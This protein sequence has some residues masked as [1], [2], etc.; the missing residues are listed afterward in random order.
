M[1]GGGVYQLHST[2]YTKTLRQSESKEYLSTV[3]V[4]HRLQSRLF[5]ESY[6][7]YTHTVWEN[8]EFLSV[9]VGGGHVVT[10][11]L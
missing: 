7:T 10:T 3:L 6:K 4:L 8:A 2:A 1:G 5:T 11:E 9:R